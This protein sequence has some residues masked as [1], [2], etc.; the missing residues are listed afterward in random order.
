MAKQKFDPNAAF[1]TIVGAGQGAPEQSTPQSK[2]RPKA[3][4]ETKKR[5]TLAVLP[6]LYEDMQKIAYVERSSVSEIV[7]N[8]F[9]RYV[10]DNAAKLKEYDTIKK[11]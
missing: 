4:R 1:N 7:T 3:D 8:F 9:E 10:T 6:S 5:V 2:G 11:D